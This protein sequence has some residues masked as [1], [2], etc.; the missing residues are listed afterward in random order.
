MVYKSELSSQ[1]AMGGGCDQHGHPG[2]GKFLSAKSNRAARRQSLSEVITSE[3][4]PRLMLIHHEPGQVDPIP[5]VGD[6]EICEFCGLAMGAD[7]SAATSYFGEMRARG[8]SIDALFVHL[9][10]PTARYLGQLWEED[11][12]DFV[13]VT[14]GVARL[15]EILTIFGG[16]RDVRLIDIRHRALLIAPRGESHVFGIDMVAR[17]MDNGGWDVTVEKNVSS[18]Q[19]ARL[20]SREWIGVVGVTL[21]AESGLESLASMIRTVRRA[22]ANAVVGVMVGGPLFNAHPE[23]AIQ[24]GADASAAD[25][26][27]AVALAKRLLMRQAAQEAIS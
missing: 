3:I 8:H 7:A 19:S 23:L 27:T 1:S 9:L 16:A 25:A 13:D 24:V 5:A 20:V 10:A 21:S 22:S 11:R 14:L 4:V 17:F 18:S 6:A 12:C 2:I 15:Q 26:P